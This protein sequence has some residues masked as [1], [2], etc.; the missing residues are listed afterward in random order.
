M[1]TDRELQ[2]LATTLALH[3]RD[4]WIKAK[5]LEQVLGWHERKIRRGAKLL[6][7]RLRGATVCSGN[8]GY[9]FTADPDRIKAAADRIERH[10]KSELAVASDMRKAANGGQISLAPPSI[11]Q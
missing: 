11:G 9:M 1:I 8:D 4:R 5:D 3:A 7:E 6:R 2:K 10:G